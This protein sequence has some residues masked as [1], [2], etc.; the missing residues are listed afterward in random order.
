MSNSSLINVTAKAHSSNYTKGRSKKISKIT[1]HHMAG[2][3]TASQCGKIFQSKNR[4]A[5]A[6]Y[7]VGTDGK[8]GLYVDEC[9]TAWSDGNWSSNCKSVSIETANSKTGGDWPVSDKTLKAL[10]KL[11]ADIA[12]RNDL[13]TLVV[14]KNL[15]YHSMYVA[16]TCPGKYLKS[17][18]QYIADE[19]NKLNEVKTTTSSTTKKTSVSKLA[20]DGL[21]G[22]TTTKR[23]QKV[24]GTTQDGI[25]SNQL[26]SCKKYLLNCQ[27]SSWEFDNGKGGS[28][29]VK[30]IQ[31]LVGST[32]DGYMGKNTVKALQKFLNKKGYSCGT[33]D[34]YMGAKT[35]KAWQRYVNSRL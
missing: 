30:A 15:T 16:T 12:K 29:T 13:G 24:L 9:N 1:I 5:S 7:G 35:V 26:K 8:I 20:V 31:K 33:V 34:G 25:V 6:H 27:T 32:R 28:P 2:K 18:M 19:A 21:W 4:G 14:G 17:K 11:V 3:L 22:K 23:T 10:I